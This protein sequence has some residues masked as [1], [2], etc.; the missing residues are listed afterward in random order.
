MCD[1]GR[2]RGER[3]KQGVGRGFKKKGGD[4]QGAQQEYRRQ[5]NLLPHRQTE[6]PHRNHGQH[7]DDD[8]EKH[9]RDGGAEEQGIIVDAFAVRIRADPGRFD[10]DALEDVGQHEGDAP[11]RDEGEEHVAG[12]LEGFA[13]AEEPVV[14]EQDG[15]FDE[16]YAD[17]V[18][19][20]VGDC[21]LFLEGG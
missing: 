9:I 19:D 16:G 8:V 17:A 18:E 13:H 1:L 4:V 2:E 10:G 5:R 6:A 20:F 21:C 7:Q 11:A 12:V 14:E 15:Y 3:E